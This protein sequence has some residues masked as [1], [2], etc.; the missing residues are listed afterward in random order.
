MLRWLSDILLLERQVNA[1]LGKVINVADGDTM[2]V[3]DR[4]KYPTQD[5]AAGMDAPEKRQAFGNVP[6]GHRDTAE[7]AP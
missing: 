3:L 2:T 6:K 7:S 4:N 5:Q 1:L